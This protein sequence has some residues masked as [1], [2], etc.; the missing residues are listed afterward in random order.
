MNRHPKLLNPDYSL[1]LVIDIQEKL[2]R[3]MPDSVKIADRAERLLEGCKVLG[4]PLWYTEQYPK[5]LGPTIEQLA[6]HCHDAP[7]FE[8][9]GFSICM[10]ADLVHAL[11]TSSFRQI[12]LVGIETHVC[13]LQSAFDL[14]HNGFQ[15]CV[16]RDAVGS[17]F[18]IDH[19]TA[20]QRMQQEKITVT[21]SESVLFEWLVK[22]GTE[23][24]KKLSALI[25]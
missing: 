14:K 16:V 11:K 8:K 19:S 10:N 3:V 18:D 17:R 25:K 6:V 4:I 22:A 12:V 7:R 23:K 13:V 9:T 2:F 1:L 24:F 15:V 21:T 5:G 20:L